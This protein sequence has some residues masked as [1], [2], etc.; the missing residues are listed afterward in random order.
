FRLLQLWNHGGRS[1]GWIRALSVIP[2]VLIVLVLHAAT[3]RALSPSIGLAA[4]WLTALS[5]VQVWVSREARPYV[6][7]NLFALLAFVAWDRARGSRRL[8]SWLGFGV[9]AAAALYAHYFALFFLASVAACTALDLARG[10]S[11]R[12]Q[13]VRG[14]LL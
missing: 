10:T 11:D 5:P 12:R 3:R 13:L 9:A 6:L 2:G 4:A 7:M 8:R 14:F 1:E